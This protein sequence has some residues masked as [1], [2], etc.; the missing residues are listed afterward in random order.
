MFFTVPMFTN[1]FYLK[2][3]RRTVNHIHIRPSFLY[4]IF[5]YKKNTY[6][7]MD[8][9]KFIQSIFHYGI[10]KALSLVLALKIA[11]SF[12][13]QQIHFKRVVVDKSASK[14]VHRIEF[15][16]D[17]SS[18]FPFY[19]NHLVHNFKVILPIIYIIKVIPYHCP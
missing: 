10:A 6:S 18:C 8:P 1:H 19:S 9:S 7:A 3:Q 2:F 14:E 17:S 12:Y 16:L 5:A 15:F 4:F 11:H 13:S